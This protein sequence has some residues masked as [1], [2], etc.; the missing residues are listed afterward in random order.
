M[1]SFLDLA[2]SIGRPQRDEILC[3]CAKCNN[4]LWARRCVVHDYL[5]SKGF[6]KGYDVWVNHGE[7][8]S[9]RMVIDDDIE[10]EDDSRYDID[11]LLFDRFRN[12]AKANGVSEGPNEDDRKFYNLVN[13]AK[14]KIHSPISIPTPS[15]SCAPPSLTL[16]ISPPL[17]RPPQPIC[18]VVHQFAD[19]SSARV[20]CSN[21]RD[22]SFNRCTS[23]I[24]SLV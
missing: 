2:Y 16:T 12:V 19:L 14:I 7:R 18:S 17:Y 3:P 15:P 4:I 5:I 24:Q 20:H 23:R 10:D 1:E 22:C 8:I 11:G 13:E 9:L 6:L 21:Y